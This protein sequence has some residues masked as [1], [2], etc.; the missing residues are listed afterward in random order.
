[1]FYNISSHNL[2]FPDIFSHTYQKWQSSIHIHWIKPTVHY[3]MYLIL[4]HCCPFLPT[5]IT[6]IF[7][8][9]ISKSFHATMLLLR[10]IP[11]V[12]YGHISI[13]CT[14]SRP[15]WSQ[16]R[17]FYCGSMY[18]ALAYIVYFIHTEHW[19]LYEHSRNLLNA[20]GSIQIV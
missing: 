19:D 15:N 13:T 1:M 12:F 18:S 6:L 4:R 20:M 10:F 3:R 16:Y 5:Y 9:Y 7:L 14:L 17:I 8:T 11:W 2:I